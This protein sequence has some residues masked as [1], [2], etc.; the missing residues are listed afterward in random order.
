MSTPAGP[1]F[2]FVQAEYPWVL[3][4]SDGRYVL[5]GHAGVPAYVLMLA[6]LGAVER[7]GL[8]GRRRRKPK[9]VEPEPG[10]VPVATSR[11]TLVAATPFVSHA[12]A[13]RWRAEVDV[14][15]EA[16][17]GLRELNRVLHAHRVAASDPYVREV[18]REG[19]LVIRVGVGEGEPLAHGHWSSAVEVPPPVPEKGRAAV[20]RPQERLA[21]VLGG[22]DVALACEEL[23][24]RARGDLTAGR[25]REAALQLR[26]ALECALAELAPWADRE[27]IAH[28][29]SALREERATVAAAA[30][31][32]INGGLDEDSA[33]EVERVLTLLESALRART[34][35]GLT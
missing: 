4:P 6:T 17:A 20:L 5:R 35:V 27:A 14:E 24:L 15:A 2:R 7:R 23:A 26:I 28:R 34:A 21:A 9:A 18:S 25:P 10:A 31:T 19:A 8:A 1:L 11:A 3:G 12:D 30:N 32:A 13:E 33:E 16:A 22:R 29:I